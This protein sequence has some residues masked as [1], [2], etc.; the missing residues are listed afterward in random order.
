MPP[1][2]RPE[3]SRL[4]I[5]RLWIDVPGFAGALDEIEKLVDSGQDGAVCPLPEHVAGSELLD[6]RDGVGGAAPL[7]VYLLGGASRVAPAAAAPLLSEKRA[8]QESRRLWRRYLVESPR[9]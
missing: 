6:P 1:S 5:G 3:R 4:G 2:V 7:A 9:S 8:L